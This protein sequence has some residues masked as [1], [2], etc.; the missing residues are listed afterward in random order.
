MLQD[1]QGQ[2]LNEA[3]RIGN[4][5][6]SKAKKDQYGIYWETLAFDLNKKTKWD[7]KENLYSGDAGI[8]LFIAELANQFPEEKYK[9]FVEEA[10]SAL[11]SRCLAHKTD[12]YA[13]YTG[14]SGVA[15]LFALLADFY[16]DEKYN[17]YAFDTING[18]E[19][20]LQKPGRVDDFL[21][22][23]AGT[24]FALVFLFS[25][26]KNENLLA[27][28]CKFLGTLYQ[29]AHL[30]EKGLYW[31]RSGRTIRGLCG[32][33][34][35]A[36][37]I[38]LVFQE[39]AKYFQYSP[40]M[41]VA[42]AAFD[43]EN[44]HF[45]HEKNNWPDFR[46]GAYDEKAEAEFQ[47]EYNNRNQNFFLQPGDMAA[48]CHGAPGVGLTRL[49]TLGDT[50]DTSNYECDIQRA[51]EKTLE[52]LE[53]PAS[54]P[55][56]FTL[57]HGRGG[58]ALFLMEV[59]SKSAKPNLLKQVVETAKGA[60]NHKEKY[61][62]YY[63]GY[64]SAGEREDLSLF[65]GTAGIGYFFLR[66]CS[67]SMLSSILNPSI[68]GVFKREATQLF[69][70]ISSPE[71]IL[72]K[73]Y[74]PKTFSYLKAQNRN[75]IENM[76]YNEKGFPGL[77][78]DFESRLFKDSLTKK[79]PFLKDVFNLE[80]ASF[81]LGLKIKSFCFLN[82]RRNVEAEKATRLLNFENK[83]QW[84]KVSISIV[85]EAKLIVTQFDWSSFNGETTPKMDTQG[86]FTTLMVPTSL[87]MT[88][89]PLSDFSE[90][91]IREIQ[92]P[93]ILSELLQLGLQLF[94]Y[95]TEAERER[96][97]HYI[98]DE[99]KEAAQLGFIQISVRNSTSGIIEED[100]ITIE[101]SI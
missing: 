68:E 61:G 80:K 28:I 5:I 22:G 64:R 73:K 17:Q 42:S 18:C 26:T 46:K 99:L 84:S 56:S 82:T 77:V 66:L 37:G 3:K 4:E 96:V 14:R 86:V 93:K 35:G 7:H 41:H 78:E 29:G 21:N 90:F 65:M 12:N 60:L 55:T 72:L 19:R 59:I 30:T 9:S 67:D 74:F 36:G 83:S 32:I 47:D 71:S 92:Q 8:I 27:S 13:F 2:I 85:S 97:T 53:Q 10:A 44:H 81:N 58:N 50:E 33:S 57:C 100:C 15:Y 89:I 40:F 23:A 98:L 6:I 34:H 63:S 52:T 88:Q 11:Y 54:A 49:N 25:K 16:R 48:W 79:D 20:F 31:D 95:S 101:E 24:L 75:E 87:G 70:R 1:I 43:Y 94:D 69:R 62:Y 45:D 51:V 76:G 91:L 39:L 38:A